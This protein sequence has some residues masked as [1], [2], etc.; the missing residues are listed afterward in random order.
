MPCSSPISNYIWSEIAGTGSGTRTVCVHKAKAQ[1]RH[2]PVAVLTKRFKGGGRLSSSRIDLS[3]AVA[4]TACQSS[5]NETLGTD[6]ILR[7]QRRRSTLF[8]CFSTC[9]HA[10]DH[11]TV[12][13]NDSESLWTL[14]DW[15]LQKITDHQYKNYLKQG[16]LSWFV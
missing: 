6:C 10:S 1:K 12:P 2:H 4:A 3:A 15:K 9:H 14:S 16:L 13:A 5:A 11:P 7:P 8:W